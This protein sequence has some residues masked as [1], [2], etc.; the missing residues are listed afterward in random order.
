MYIGQYTDFTSKDST[1][2]TKYSWTKIKGETGAKGDAGADAI[3]INITTSAGTVFKNNSGSTVLTAHVY[4]GGVEQSITDAG[5]CGTLG[6]IKWYKGT[7][8]TAA[9]TSKTL[10]VTASDVTNSMAITCRLEK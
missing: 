1:D 6:S 10:T 8:T 5:V 7:S 4:K 2:P 9:S 3:S